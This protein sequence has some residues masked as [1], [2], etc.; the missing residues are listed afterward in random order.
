MTD[1]DIVVRNQLV[2]LNTTTVQPVYRS[3]L[4]PPN[5]KVLPVSSQN[6]RYPLPQTK[7][8]TTTI[9]S[10][11][12]I[13]PT[14]ALLTWNA[15]FPLVNYGGS[16]SYSGGGKSYVGEEVTVEWMSDA[17]ISCIQTI[18][19]NAQFQIYVDGSRIAPS[20]FSTD[21]SGS[22]YAMD[23]DFGDQGI[24]RHWKIRGI[25]FALRG[26]QIGQ[27]DTLWAVNYPT[28]PEILFMGDSYTF[29]NGTSPSDVSQSY[30]NACATALGLGYLAEGAGHYRRSRTR[31]WLCL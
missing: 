5:F 28:T 10:P 2:D 23:V 24:A 27:Y 11:Q 20:S 17:Q 15:I 26:I 9:T 18:G 7:G 12:T 4:D 19:S 22:A 14:S 8:G 29:G 3:R 30:C 21:S 13:G 6:P 31:F 25:N 1:A 16:G